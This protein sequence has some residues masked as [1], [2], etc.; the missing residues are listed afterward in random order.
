MATWGQAFL[1]LFWSVP[2]SCSSNL[3]VKRLNRPRRGPATR[4]AS[5]VVFVWS[6]ASPAA[7]SYFWPFYFYTSQLM[8]P[9]RTAK[10]GHLAL[11]SFTSRVLMTMMLYQLWDRSLSSKSQTVS[12][13][14]SCVNLLVKFNWLFPFEKFIVFFSLFYR[15]RKKLRAFTF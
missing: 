15:R 5:E 9:S 7:K 14:F 4:L 12:K 11:E 2:E 3:L 13:Y 8:S 1:P 6:S 10:D